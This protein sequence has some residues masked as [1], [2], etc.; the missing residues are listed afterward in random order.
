VRVLFVCT[1]NVC[2]SPMAREI[3]EALAGDRGLDLRAR[4]AGV[5]A[6]VGEPMTPEAAAVLDELGF[7]PEEHRARQV[8][9]A[10]LEES[11]LVLAMSPRHLEALDKLLGGGPMP[12]VHLL[13]EYATGRREGIPDPYGQTMTAYRSTARQ[14]LDH[15]ERA[16]DR[17][18]SRGG[19]G[20]A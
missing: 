13:T 15:I 9:R 5:S 6:L 20:K 10:M 16:L 3:F 2:R 7:Y 19:S 18:Q 8:S 4:S 14:L 17:L 11:D 12:E 1:A